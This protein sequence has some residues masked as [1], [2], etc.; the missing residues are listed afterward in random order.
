M[1][2]YKLMRCPYCEQDLVFE[3]NTNQNGQLV[4]TM[5]EEH[6]IPK[7]L[8]NDTFILPKGII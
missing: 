5:S 7:S 1:K 8:G 3:G 4:N 6:I 2:T